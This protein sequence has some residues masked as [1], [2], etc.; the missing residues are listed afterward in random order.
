M[1]DSIKLLEDLH[2]ALDLTKMDDKNLGV[3]VKIILKNK[4]IVK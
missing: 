2:G 1:K 4:P 3:L